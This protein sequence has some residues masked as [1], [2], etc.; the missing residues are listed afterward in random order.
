[1]IIYHF[2]ELHFMKLVFPFFFFLS[3]CAHTLMCVC[4][5]YIQCCRCVCAHMC[6]TLTDLQRLIRLH[7]LMLLQVLHLCCFNICYI[8]TWRQV[9]I[10]SSSLIQSSIDGDT[11]RHFYFI[12]EGHICISLCRMEPECSHCK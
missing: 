9:V 1:M 4:M 10:F 5:Y 7:F 6:I 2:K 12:L 11:E 3:L 8:G